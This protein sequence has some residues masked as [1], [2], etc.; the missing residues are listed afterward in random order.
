MIPKNAILKTRLLINQVLSQNTRL[1]SF[2]LPHFHNNNTLLINNN[3]IKSSYINIIRNQFIHL[4]SFD[5][6][7]D[8]KVC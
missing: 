7:K 2:A 3:T 1:I 8:S 5:C 4:K 6:K